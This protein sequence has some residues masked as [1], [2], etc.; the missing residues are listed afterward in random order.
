M[1]DK[2]WCEG[3]RAS[4]S[5]LSPDLFLLI[6]PDFRTFVWMD[7]CPIRSDGQQ[8]LKRSSWEENVSDVRS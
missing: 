5:L 8:E 7:F 3:G 2:R 1:V 6:S 4:V